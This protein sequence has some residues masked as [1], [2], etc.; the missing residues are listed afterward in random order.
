MTKFEEAGVELQYTAK[1][2]KGAD[3]RYEKSCNICC[4]HGLYIKCD[5]CAIRQAHKLAIAALADKEMQQCQCC[6]CN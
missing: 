5:H 1:T 4:H 3:A 6:N 2:K